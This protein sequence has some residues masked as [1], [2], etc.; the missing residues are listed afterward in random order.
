MK[1]TGLR[2]MSSASP[3]LAVRMMDFSHSGVD[4]PSPDGGKFWSRAQE[5]TSLYAPPVRIFVLI[6]VRR[7]R[8]QKVGEFWSLHSVEPSLQNRS[9]GESFQ[10]GAFVS[11]KVPQPV[12]QR[13]DT[14]NVT[15]P[16][17]LAAYTE[18][19]RRP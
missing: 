1:V 3:A 10:F 5:S 13:S 19:A 11:S 8:D 9:N 15:W 12:R 14:S 18:S 6:P 17:A 4:R 16:I 2:G 7:M